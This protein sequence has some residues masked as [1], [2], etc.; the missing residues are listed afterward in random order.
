MTEPSEPTPT[1]T[2][3][4]VAGIVLAR[5]LEGRLYRWWLDRA[6]RIVRREVAS[7]DQLA[8]TA[9]AAIRQL[10]QALGNM[11]EEERRLLQGIEDGEA[12]AEEA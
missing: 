9:A 2:N 7:L 12:R 11:D 8:G 6:A 10:A 1:L 5:W 4:Y 3:A